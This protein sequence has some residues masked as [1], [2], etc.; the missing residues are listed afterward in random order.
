[1]NHLNDFFSELRSPK[2]I[3][4]Q[5]PQT[6]S[7]FSQ[8][9]TLPPPHVRTASQERITAILHSLA[10]IKPFLLTNEGEHYSSFEFRNIEILGESLLSVNRAETLEDVFRQFAL[11]RSWMFCMELRTSTSTNVYRELGAKFIRLHFYGFLEAMIPYFP[12]G[13]RG[14]LDT[15]CGNEIPELRE[16]VILEGVDDITKLLEVFW[17][18]G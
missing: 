8:A 9:H 17:T 7:H 4:K 2:F 12:P 13:C 15:I 11:L 10:E 14:A 3:L 1:M 5:F 16:E 18:Q 6:S